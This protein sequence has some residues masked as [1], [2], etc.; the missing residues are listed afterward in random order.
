M[1]KIV[2]L[3]EDCKSRASYLADTTLPVFYMSDF[4]LMGLMV[5]RYSDALELLESHGLLLEKKK[6]GSDLT[7]ENPSHIL[8]IQNLLTENGITS[9]YSDIAD[10][11]YQA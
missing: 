9:Q 11:I 10:T 1:G 4:T 8:E 2:I 6:G 7:V 5:S 3:P